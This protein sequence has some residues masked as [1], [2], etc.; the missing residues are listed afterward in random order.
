MVTPHSWH[1]AAKQA[2]DREN[3]PET[4]EYRPEPADSRQSASIDVVA[5]K[6]AGFEPDFNVCA[7]CKHHGSNH[8]LNNVCLECCCDCDLFSGMGEDEKWA[9]GV[10][11]YSRLA[12]EGVSR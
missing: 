1:K 7:A 4:P 11:E 9:W 12:S 2:L 10:A 5:L 6:A 8:D 3:R